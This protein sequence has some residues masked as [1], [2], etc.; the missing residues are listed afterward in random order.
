MDSARVLGCL[1]VLYIELRQIEQERVSGAT[2]CRVQVGFGLRFG[3]GFDRE[4]LTCA[5]LCESEQQHK[6][7]QRH[8]IPHF[9]VVEETAAEE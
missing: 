2:A 3:F 9:C 7:L 5:A 8:C 4:R 6:Q 1:P